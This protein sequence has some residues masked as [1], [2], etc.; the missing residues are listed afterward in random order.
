MTD[1]NEEHGLQAAGEPNRIADALSS[2][3]ARMS[4]DERIAAW[5]ASDGRMLVSAL[6]HS[7]DRPPSYLEALAIAT[8]DLAFDQ[9]G[10][11]N[12]TPDFVDA[13]ERSCSQSAE[14]YSLAKDVCVIN[15]SFGKLQSELQPLAALILSGRLSKPRPGKGHGSKTWHRDLLLVRGIS[16]TVKYG[17][18]PM[19][20]DVSSPIS[21]CDLTIQAFKKAGHKDRPTYQTV[22]HAWKKRAQ[23]FKDLEDIDF[24]NFR[25]SVEG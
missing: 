22:K 15:L 13:L 17:I 14:Y 21:G 18:R 1:H 4:Q 10:Y 6:K 23:L 25:R 7:K 11:A 5:W 24:A 9:D 2:R 3:L 8:G 20:N 16:S 12:V 19:R